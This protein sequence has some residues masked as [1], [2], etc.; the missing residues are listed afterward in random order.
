MMNAL[1]KGGRR[2]KV[3]DVVGDSSV[4][5]CTYMVQEFPDEEWFDGSGKVDLIDVPGFLDPK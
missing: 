5:P 4:N 3:A 2:A 1:R